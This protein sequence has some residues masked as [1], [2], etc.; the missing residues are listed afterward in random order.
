MYELSLN[1]SVKSRS[2]P[3]S[4]HQNSSSPSLPAAA[5]VEHGMVFGLFLRQGVSQHGRARMGM[6]LWLRD[7]DEGTARG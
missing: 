7:E 1:G 6:A 4:T 5:A 2:R 3:I